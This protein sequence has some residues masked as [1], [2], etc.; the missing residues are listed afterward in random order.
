MRESTGLLVLT[1]SSGKCSAVAS[2]GNHVILWH[3]VVDTCEFPI[4]SPTLAQEILLHLLATAALLLQLTFEKKTWI[5][6]RAA[7]WPK[8]QPQ[9]GFTI[10]S[11]Y[12]CVERLHHEILQAGNPSHFRAYGSCW[13][14]WPATWG[15]WLIQMKAWRASSSPSWLSCMWWPA[16]AD[17]QA[18][19]AEPTPKKRQHEEVI[20][21]L[22]A[23]S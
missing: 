18:E 21:W 13:I 1:Q 3:K 11:T 12:Y 23:R 19:Q 20:V 7:V 14:R 6:M 22:S 2:C 8:L 17:E 15:M 10:L 16:C 5:P 9:P 4:Q